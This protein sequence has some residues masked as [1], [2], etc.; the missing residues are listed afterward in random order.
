PDEA[1]AA[2]ELAQRAL[3]HPVLV[4]AAA[5]A[6]HGQCRR[7]TPVAMEV[8]GVLVEGVVD[9][10]FR[11]PG[12]GPWTVV[13]FKTDLQIGARHD[14]YV[15][16]VMLYARAIAEATGEPAEAVLLQL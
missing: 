8:D 9:A 13:D 6:R 14:D 4:R 5:A 15:R 16:Q 11:D 3:A 10:A 7:E 1:T 2:A 12:G